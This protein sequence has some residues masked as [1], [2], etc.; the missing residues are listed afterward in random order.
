MGT[1]DELDALVS[2]LVD[3]GVRPTID[4]TFPLAD[5][6]QA[7]ERLASGDVVG[8]LVLTNG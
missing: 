2:L 5:A 8:K 3:T 7:F 1:R 6:R 4:A